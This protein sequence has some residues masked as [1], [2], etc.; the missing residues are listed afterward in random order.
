MNKKPLI[1]IL[2]LL[3]LSTLAFTQAE[4]I[5]SDDF[6]S[7]INEA[8][9]KRDYQV[10][11]NGAVLR[12]FLEEET[13]NSGEKALGV[14]IISSNPYNNSNNGSIY[15]SLGIFQDNW[16]GATGIRFWISNPNENPLLISFNLKERYR[17]YWA[18]AENGVF[19]FQN[20]AGVISQQ[21]I[22]YNNLPIPAHFQGWVI[23]P[24]VSLAVPDWNT[25]KSNDILDTNKIESY[26]FSVEV[27]EITS[28]V[29]FM[30]DIEVFKQNTFST[31]SIDGVEHIQIPRSGE[32]LESFSA[33]LGSLASQT[34]EGVTVNWSIQEPHDP[35]VSINEEGVLRI[36]ADSLNSVINLVAQYDTPEFILMNTFDVTLEGGEV[37]EG[38]EPPTIEVT[39]PAVDQVSD[40]E[41]FLAKFDTWTTE[42]RALFVV[43]LI[44]GVTFFLFILSIIERKLK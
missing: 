35:A 42:N 20:Q 22:L 16:S 10:W 28:L 18:V 5:F 25:A 36:P 3:I 19:Y 43:L 7:H 8:K 6:E 15:R 37:T 31:L 39:S 21:E 40:Y 44:L 38:E 12:I 26:S 13:V 41:N 17:E 11:E 30:D 29:F 1:L 34:T 33:H 4:T 23:I 2:V 24:F 9:L 32:L 27:G 14:E